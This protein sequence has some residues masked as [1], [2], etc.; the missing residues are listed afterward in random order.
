MAKTIPEQIRRSREQ[1]RSSNIDMT[2][3]VAQSLGICSS[4]V[5]SLTSSQPFA[6]LG[7]RFPIG[8]SVCNTTSCKQSCR[9]RLHDY[10]PKPPV[11]GSSCFPMQAHQSLDA[12]SIFPQQPDNCKNPSLRLAPCTE[13]AVISAPHSRRRNSHVR[14]P[15]PWPVRETSARP[16][17]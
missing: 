1:G 13:T 17:S 2:R 9:C 10:T 11:G 6:L 3:S 15:A 12:P 5:H 8:C 7:L 14:L 4:N 16:P